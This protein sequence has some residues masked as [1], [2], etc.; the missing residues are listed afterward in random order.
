M[1][2]ELNNYT[3]I[4]LMVGSLMVP[5]AL[6]FEHEVQYYKKWKYLFPAILLTAIPFI[7][8]DI[9]FEKK[10]IWSFNPDFLTGYYILNL[11]V[12]EWLFFIVVPFS[13]TFIYEVLKVKIPRYEKPQLYSYLLLAVIIVSLL[14]FAFNTSR[15]YTAVNFLFLTAY[16]AFI[17]ATKWF[18]PHYTKFF[19][20]WL[21]GLIPFFVI[22]GIL[23]GMPVVE[24]NDMQ[25]LGIRLGTIPVEDSGYF[26]LLF[27]MV[28]SIYEYLSIRKFY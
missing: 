5:L 27:L 24:Y 9:I 17:Y 22:N 20:A 15:L 8:W 18:K 6:S 23:T 19:I 2:M 11:P 16:S 21:V 25:N 7:V 13:C 28:V 4:L 26:L 14:I 12:E 1:I 3:Y 10:G